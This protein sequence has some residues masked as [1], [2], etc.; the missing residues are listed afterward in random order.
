MSHSFRLITL[1][2][3]VNQYESMYIRET[4]V[5]EGWRETPFQESADVVIVNTCV[6]TQRAAHQSRQ[7]IRR[8]VRESPNGLVAAVGC[9]PQTYP[10]VISG[11]PG[12]GVVAGNVGKASLPKLL[13]HAADSGTRH[14]RTEEFQPDMPF[15]PMPIRHRG[16]RTRAFL[17]IQDG[18]R[19]FCAYCIVP[20][21]RGPCRSLPVAEVLDGLLSLCEEGYREVVLTGVHLGRYGSDLPGTVSLT[22]LLREIGREGFP[23]RIRLSSLE[24]NEIQRDMVE[25]IG[26]ETWLCPHFHIPL[27]SGDDGILHRMNRT[28][29]RNEF[30]AVIQDIHEILPHAAVGVDVIAGFPGEDDGAHEN[31]CSLLKGLPISYLHVFPFSP[32]PGTA[33]AG[34]DGRVDSSTVKQRAA[35]LRQLGQLKRDRFYGSCVGRQLAV[36]VEERY[37]EDGGLLQGTS[38]NYLSVLFS[39]PRNTQGQIVTVRATGVEK[40][41]IL[42]AAVEEHP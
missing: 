6:V 10:E 18:C 17:K 30:A 37:R 4:L 16:G 23:I 8:A 42:G 1:G 7:A 32:M 20:Y 41:K 12:V 2:C 22:R 14:I 24:P 15:E 33:A 40:N 39:S 3:K 21:A 35:E 13:L 27:Q 25:M 36:L 26:T 34:F 28:Y 31:T 11:I 9:Y 38:E 5:Q 29:R 19:S